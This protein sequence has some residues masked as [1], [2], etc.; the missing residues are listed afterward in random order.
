MKKPE[1]MF[2]DL[3]KDQADQ[4]DELF[5]YVRYCSNMGKKGILLAQVFE[6]EIKE[7]TDGVDAFMRVGFIDHKNALKIKELHD[8]EMEKGGK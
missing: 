4:L 2:V 5:R 6:G 8:K 1:S 7:L 3:T